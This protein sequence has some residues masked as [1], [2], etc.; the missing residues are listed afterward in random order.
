MV[1]VIRKDTIDC[2][3]YPHHQQVFHVQR[4]LIPLSTSS[5]IS[6]VY[7]WVSIWVEDHA[8]HRNTSSTPASTHQISDSAIMWAGDAVHFGWASFSCPNELNVKKI[9]WNAFYVNKLLWSSQQGNDIGIA[10]YNHML[11]IHHSRGRDCSGYYE[12]HRVSGHTPIPSS[13]QLWL[14]YTFKYAC[15][16]ELW[17]RS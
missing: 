8:F 14:E 10:I 3:H 11:C 16:N 15:G 13:S 6:Q 4:C 17:Q 1:A 9:Y 12:E 2:F 5:S 7:C